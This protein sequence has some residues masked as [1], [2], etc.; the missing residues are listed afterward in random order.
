MISK[1]LFVE[2]IDG[3]M[4]ID[5]YQKA[6]NKL[7]NK[8]RADGYLLEPTNNDII[9]RLLMQ[10]IP[11]DCDYD[12]LTAF[13]FDNNYGRGKNKQYYKDKNGQNIELKTPEDLY[14]YLIKNGS[15]DI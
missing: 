7:Y 12:A 11:H 1:E 9:I 2:A 10:L 6:K 4:N 13:C 14:D 5:D 15:D 8:F 3:M